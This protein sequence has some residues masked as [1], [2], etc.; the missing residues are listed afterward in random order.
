MGPVVGLSALGALVLRRFPARATAV[1]ANDCHNAAPD[2]ALAAR[3]HSRAMAPHPSTRRGA[4]AVAI[5]A[6]EPGVCP[7][8]VALWLFVQLAGAGQR[9]GAHAFRLHG[10]GHRAGGHLF[11]HPETGPGVRLWIPS[12]GDAGRLHQRRPAGVC[13]IFGADGESGAFRASATRACRRADA[14]GGCRPR[15][16]FARPHRRA[17]FLVPHSP[18]RLA[19]ERPGVLGAYLG[20]DPDVGSAAVTRERAS[21]TGCRD[22]TKAIPGGVAAGCGVRDVAH[23]ESALFTCLIP[24]DADEATLLRRLLVTL[25]GAYGG[26]AHLSLEL[27]R[28]KAAL[29]AHGA[30]ADRPIAMN[31]RASHHCEHTFGDAK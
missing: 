4:A 21:A 6:A 12:A 5:P 28:M 24:A 11:G 14:C 2:H 22:V 1:E 13:V 16:E 30:P 10:A 18:L 19:L 8:G 3:S 7:G 15:G 17:P 29:D 9:C 26:D 23:R 27:I 31:V 25:Q 20:A